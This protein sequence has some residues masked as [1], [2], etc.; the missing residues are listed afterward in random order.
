MLFRSF[1]EEG[2]SRWLFD[3]VEIPALV[4]L[5]SR[6]A[7]TGWYVAGGPAFAVAIDRKLQIKRS[8]DGPWEDTPDC[9]CGF[10]KETEGSVVLQGGVTLERFLI[11]GRFTQGLTDIVDVGDQAANA[12]SNSRSRVFAVLVGLRF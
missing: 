3:F 8:G 5:G 2:R 9:A 7:S 6:Q 10:L 12:P 11:E 1:Q 4:R